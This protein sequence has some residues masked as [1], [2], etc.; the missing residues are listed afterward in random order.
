MPQTE[1]GGMTSTTNQPR[2]VQPASRTIPAW[3]IVLTLL[4]SVT[5]LCVFIFG[6]QEILA[7]SAAISWCLLPIA[8]L[9]FAGSR[10]YT[11]LAHPWTVIFGLLLHGW[12]LR[13][14]IAAFDVSNSV[15]VLLR[16]SDASILDRGLLIST[17]AIGALG[18]G[19][20]LTAPGTSKRASAYLTRFHRLDDKD[21]WR[22]GRMAFA[23]TAVLLIA[24]AGIYLLAM[25]G[26]S[27]IGKRFNDIQGGSASRLTAS[28]YV[29]LRMSYLS[30]SAFI[31]LMVYK[32]KFGKLPN[33]FFRVL[34]VLAFVG[35]LLGPLMSDSR[36]G[37]ALVLI[38]I[39]MLQIILSGRVRI[40]RI[41]ATGTVG[42]VALATMLQLR[43]ETAESLSQATL[44]IFTG[45]DLFDIG[46]TA[47]I[48][49]LPGGALGGETLVGWI[50]V[51]VPQSL[52]P[53]DKP[54]F[55]ELG[56]Y[57]WTNAYGA[58]NASGVP[59]GIIG[60][61]YLNFGTGAIIVGMLGFGVILG[62]SYRLLAFDLG[63]RRV[64]AAVLM[65]IGLVRLTVFG[66]S[67]DL[68]TGVLSSL[69][70]MV[71]IL[72]LL[73][74]VAPRMRTNSRSRRPSTPP[75]VQ[76]RPVIS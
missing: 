54:M 8:A 52:L 34:T 21:A 17:M 42:L 48:L 2:A 43:S 49:Q 37:V 69:G 57:V 74:F 67:N 18:V 55:T 40:G 50:F 53:F 27:F 29:Y 25:S 12:A 16:G 59:A 33:G 1:L 38:D 63:E 71:P 4:C 22:P 28:S 6:P 60:E 41:V 58:S 36:A 15:T 3:W 19:Y 73:A 10:G 45:R 76:D 56:Q 7:G 75:P 64:I 62:L 44:S 35:A 24:G 51:L 68:G 9:P 14:T 61:L 23:L 11:S 20:A 32:F 70:D 13:L 31:V 39:L 65:A 46:K 66:L 47:H 26:D 72:L 5:S 30:H